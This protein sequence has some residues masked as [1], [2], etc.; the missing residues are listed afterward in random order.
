MKL[1][2][3]ILQAQAEIRAIRRD[4]HAH[5]ELC[6]EEQR[7]ADVVASN[8]ESWGIE[9]HRGL[10]TTG[11]VGVLRSGNG[12][13]TIG[14]RA[15]MDAL[16]LQEANTFGHR[17]RHEG[18]MHACGHDGHTAMLLGAARYLAEHRNFDGTVNFIFQPAEEG[19][20]GAREMIKDGLF[21]RFPCDAVFGMHN[22]PG[23]PAGSFGTTAGPLMA[24]SNE[25]KI[26]VRG[27][28]AHAAMPNNGCDPVF[29]GAQIVSALQGI[30][31]RNKRPIDTAV[32]SVTQ[33]HGGDAT[34]IVPNEVWLGG[35]V[36][37]F[38]VPVL[39]LIERRMEEV[40]RAVAQAFDCT[41]DFEFRR[42]YPPTINSAAEAEFAVEIASELVGASNVDGNVE[43]TMGAED[44]SFMLQERPGCYL[45]IGN[46]EGSHREAGHGMGP[47]MLHNPSYDFND[48]L[49][50]VGSTFFVKLVEK[51]LAPS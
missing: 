19:G 4:I 30:I 17:S 15:D 48:E 14:L 27:K 23:M 22:W 38:T 12:G 11:L 20:G 33:F 9:V 36:R 37:T 16:P 43:P 3:E 7:T 5:P 18:K 31:T 44:F 25:F 47:C 2:P 24:S 21:E 50:P 46:G 10:G 6:F 29:T 35:T 42:N 32:I 34:N 49:L 39:D 1:I 13:R 45:F 28:G 8:L 26:V 51:W 40:A 41:I